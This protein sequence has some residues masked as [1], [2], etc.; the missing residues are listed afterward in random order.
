MPNKN[1]ASKQQLDS[2]RTTFSCRFEQILCDSGANPI[3][4]ISF[5]PL[6]SVAC[7]CASTA[8]ELAHGELGVVVVLTGVDDPRTLVVLVEEEI[9]AIDLASDDWPTFTL[10]Y[11]VSLHCSAITCTT[12]S[13]NVPKTLWDKLVDAGRQQLENSSSRV[14]WSIS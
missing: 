9:V 12:H 4:Y 5:S 6:A 1:C 13:A 3:E 8:S 14:S 11:L 7:H 2:E 10:P